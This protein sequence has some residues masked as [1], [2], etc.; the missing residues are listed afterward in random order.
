MRRGGDERQPSGPFEWFSREVF[1][2]ARVESRSSTASARNTALTLVSSMAA[3]TSSAGSHASDSAGPVRICVAVYAFGSGWLVHRKIGRNTPLAGL[4]EEVADLAGVPVSALRFLADGQRITGTCTIGSCQL[5]HDDTI[6]AMVEQGSP[7]AQH[8]AETVRETSK[9]R[10]RTAPVVLDSDDEAGSAPTGAVPPSRPP[11]DCS[12]SS[13]AG[14][15]AEAPMCLSSDDEQPA[16]APPPAAT[17]AQLVPM[18]GATLTPT[19]TPRPAA[20]AATAIATAAAAA[21]APQAAVSSGH[22]AA[23]TNGWPPQLRSWIERSFAKCKTDAERAVTQALLKERISTANLTGMLWAVHWDT[24]PLAG[25]AAKQLPP[26]AAAARAPAASGSPLP[27]TANDTSMYIFERVKGGGTEFQKRK[28]A[29]AKA[30]GANYR[31]RVCGILAADWGSMQFHVESSE[32]GKRDPCE[33]MPLHQQLCPRASTSQP[34]PRAQAVWPAATTTGS[35]ALAPAAIPAAIPA[36]S[37]ASAS[38]LLP[39][40]TL[41]QPLP[42]RPQPPPPQQPPPQP[43]PPQWQQQQAWQ[44]LGEAA[45]RQWRA[46]HQ[47]QP[48]PQ[49]VSGLSVEPFGRPCFFMT[50]PPQMQP[51]LMMPPVGMRPPSMPFPR[52]PTPPPGFPPAAAPRQ[53]TPPGPP[54]AAALTPP[55]GAQPRGKR[56]KPIECL[57]LLL[58]FDGAK[59]KLLPGPA[60][61]P[62]PAPSG[63]SPAIDGEPSSSATAGLE[64]VA[65]SLSQADLD[66][67]QWQVTPSA[68]G[69]AVI[70]AEQRLSVLVPPAPSEGAL[71]NLARLLSTAPIGGATAKSALLMVLGQAAAAGSVIDFRRALDCVPE[72]LVTPPLYQI[73]LRL[74]AH[75]T[76]GEPTDGETAVQQLMACRTFSPAVHTFLR[77]QGG[78]VGLEAGASFRDYFVRLSYLN[79]LEVAAEVRSARSC[80]CPE[81]RSSSASASSSA[82]GTMSTSTRQAVPS[83]SAALVQVEEGAGARGVYEHLQLRRV[84]KKLEG[85]LSPSAPQPRP[86]DSLL[87][88]TLARPSRRGVTG[89][90]DFGSTGCDLLPRRFRLFTIG[91]VN[92]P[93]EYSMQPEVTFSLSEQDGAYPASSPLVA[94]D[95]APIRWDPDPSASYRAVTGPSVSSC[96]RM[97]VALETLTFSRLR[98]TPA[99]LRLCSALCINAPPAQDPVCDDTSVSAAASSADAGL[100]ASQRQAWRAATDTGRPL[101]LIQGPPGTGKTH[102]CVAIVRRWLEQTT[103]PSS[104]ATVGVPEPV[105]RCALLAE[106]QAEQT[107]QDG[108]PS[109]RARHAYEDEWGGPAGES[110]DELPSEDVEPE[111]RCRILVTGFSNV[112]IDNLASGLL[113]HGVRVVRAGRGATQLKHISLRELMQQDPD[114]PYLKDLEKSPDPKS[115]AKARELEQTLQGRVVDGADVVIATC[116]SSG[117]RDLAFGLSAHTFTHVLMDEAAQ[118]SEPAALVPLTQGCEKLVLVGDQ[119]QLAPQL[120]SNVAQR[121]GLGESLFGRLVRVGVHACFLDTQYRMHPALA[122]YPSAAFY[123]GRLASGVGEDDRPPPRGIAW[124]HANADGQGATPLAFLGIGDE[125][126]CNEDGFAVEVQV[127]TSRANRDEAR[128]LATV[129]AQLTRNLPPGGLAI[130]T[131]YAAQ[132]DAL[133]EELR[134]ARVEPLPTIATVDSFQGMEHEVILVSAVRASRHGMA[135]AGF[136][137]DVRRLNVLLTRARRGLLLVGHIATLLRDPAWGGLLV[138]MWRRGLVNGEG[139]E[140]LQRLGAADGSAPNMGSA[141]PQVRFPSGPRTW[142]AFAGR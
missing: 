93:K 74:A 26:P 5:N 76:R 47:H 18:V 15:S 14:S 28:K 134:R 119:A 81:D 121:L 102:T 68:G 1:L 133:R 20:A 29:A 92:Q 39:L 120:S 2:R 117:G 37:P 4:M 51:P 97:D 65:R 90:S 56:L 61:S 136:L 59:V 138:D 8:W 33:H 45:L 43:P 24:E 101:T 103:D 137:S 73:A 41:L 83:A 44:T 12:S 58:T 13:L 67:G 135:G 98:L 82:G 109:K 62:S 70:I 94:R 48:Q 87:V 141:A 122:A 126:A 23:G 27:A 10:S 139:R 86:G 130:I 108:R 21:P 35:G 89:G 22:H 17:P 52:Q 80:L 50:P 124:P 54:P 95:A 127:G 75:W 131:P 49:L 9:K 88:D 71:R 32:H 64:G 30:A 111:K 16:A 34:A 57:Q 72:R 84:G 25:S 118:A 96:R 107:A 79:S 115:W 3:A 106:L 125:A 123:A 19:L 31:C 91:Q 69:S 116:I 105:G 113:R 78:V 42:R 55:L 6:D 77:Q 46:Q 53:P 100:N 140:P 132:I 129:A 114:W 110:A 11:A 112:A 60:T 7:A 40:P 104:P 36:A 85:A 99:Q 66:V 63:A 38:S 128:V 142:L